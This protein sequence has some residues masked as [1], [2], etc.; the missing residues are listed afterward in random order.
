MQQYVPSASYGAPPSSGAATLWN[1]KVAQ[2][3]SFVT[4]EDFSRLLL[5]LDGC[6]D[7]RL[8]GRRARRHARRCGLMATLRRA[9][10]S[11][12]APPQAAGRRPG[13]V[14]RVL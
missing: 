1:L 10:R 5:Q 12:L 14:C 9:D 7:A 4:Q 2:V 6:V 13:R 3:P 11:P 8:M